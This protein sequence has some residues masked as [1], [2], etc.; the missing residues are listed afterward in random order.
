LKGR[1]GW[2]K[3]KIVYRGCKK[4]VKKYRKNRIKF[5]VDASQPWVA[6]V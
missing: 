4:L 3:A 5:K 1:F 6:I 2:V